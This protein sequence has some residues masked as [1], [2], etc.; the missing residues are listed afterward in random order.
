M[1]EGKRPVQKVDEP[2]RKSKKPAGEKSMRRPRISILA[3]MFERMKRSRLRGDLPPDC[4][5]LEFHWYADQYAR[6]KFAIQ[7]GQVSSGVIASEGTAWGRLELR[8]PIFRNQRTGEEM[9]FTGH[10]M[11][12]TLL[13]EPE[14]PPEVNQTE[15]YRW[16]LEEASV[17]QEVVHL[18]QSGN[19]M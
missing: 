17:D 14:A 8:D 7:T 4:P 1:I 5:L 13:P 2:E 19:R 9:D 3:I 11:V 12:V 10:H 18:H 6:L 16:R 15:N